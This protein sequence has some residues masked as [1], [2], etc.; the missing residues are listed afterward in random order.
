M[1][2]SLIVI[3]G[4]VLLVLAWLSRRTPQPPAG[5]RLPEEPG[6]E[7]EDPVAVLP[8]EDCIDLHG[9]RPRDILPVVESYLE[10]AAAKGFTEVRLIHGKGKGVQRRRVRELLSRHPL[11]ERF[12]DAPAHRGGWGATIAWLERPTSRRRRAR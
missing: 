10:E 5:T 3:V 12:D 7:E 11:V 4:L 8:I 2:L 1:D 6:D 9:F